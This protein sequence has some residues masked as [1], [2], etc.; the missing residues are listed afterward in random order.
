VRRGHA[1]SDDRR[2][3]SGRGR[4]LG[5]RTSGR[6]CA[7]L[8]GRLLIEPSGSDPLTDFFNSAAA[9]ASTSTTLFASGSCS[10][11]WPRHRADA[12]LRPQSGGMPW[13][14]SSSPRSDG[15]CVRPSRRGARRSRRRR[16]NRG[17]HRVRRPRRCWCRG[18]CPTSVCAVNVSGS[19]DK[20]AV[21]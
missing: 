20:S 17:W 6:R 19:R 4:P 11:A 10:S 14:S 2:R 21:G 3:A 9:R 13:R 1:R 5:A 15:A 7:G 8:I 18:S 16:R 12:P